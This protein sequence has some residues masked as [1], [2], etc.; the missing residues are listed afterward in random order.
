[1]GLKV[2]VAAPFRQEGVRE[3]VESEFVVALSL[4]RDWYSP[5]QAK[6]LLD[7][8]AGEGLLERTDDG[9]RATFDPESV[10]VPEGFSPDESLLAGRSAFEQVLDD[11][12][13]AG[14][15][16]REAVAAINDRQDRLGV[17]IEA[18]AVLHARGE[19][20]DPS[21]AARTALAE[22]R[23]TDDGGREAGG[24]SEAGRA[25]QEA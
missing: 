19:G 1:M 17:S 13:A 8:A 6:R 22:L 9:V 25:E 16:K 18:A 20:V 24:D 2:A 12:V 23:A 21:A 14:A 7:R 11:L 3:L 10:A 15:D 5:D 4:D